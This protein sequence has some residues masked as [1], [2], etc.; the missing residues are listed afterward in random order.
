[1]KQT[2][3]CNE[4][5]FLPSGKWA[6]RGIPTTVYDS[7]VRLLIRCGYKFDLTIDDV[8]KTEKK[9]SNVSNKRK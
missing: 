8:E 3:I 5:I 2:V 1:M 9:A 6:K 7:D 4:D